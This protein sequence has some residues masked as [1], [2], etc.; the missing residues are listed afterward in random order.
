MVQVLRPICRMGGISYGRVTE[1]LELTRPDFEKDLGG[2][3]GAAK[4]Q[5]KH[6]AN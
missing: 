1:L 5:R 2:L 3:E 4:L 6:P